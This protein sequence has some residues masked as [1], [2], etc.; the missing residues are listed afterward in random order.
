[1]ALLYRAGR[2][3]ASPLAA[4]LATAL[5]PAMA[6][7]TDAVEVIAARVGTVAV[8]VDAD[9][10]TAA[11]ARTAA[12][13]VGERRQFSV[14]DGRRRHG[15][16]GLPCDGTAVR[17]PPSGRPERHIGFDVASSCCARASR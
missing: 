8:E 3:G 15:M 2:S 11:A 14:L 9:R 1:M 7:R 10:T 5:D 17:D 12:R 16:P 13:L 6:A 4:L